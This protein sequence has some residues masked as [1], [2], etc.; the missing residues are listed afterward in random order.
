VSSF[1]RRPRCAVAVLVVALGVLVAGG[2]PA[3]AS[4]A[5]TG[6]TDEVSDNGQCSLREAITVLNEG[7]A[8]DCTNTAT[9][10]TTINVPAGDYK[11]TLR[12]SGDDA[13]ETGDL[14]LLGSMT[15]QGA[16]AGS[17]FIDGDTANAG[18]SPDRVL[19]IIQG[20]GGQMN[21]INGVTVENGQ[22]PPA[23][24][25]AANGGGILIR[26]G[27]VTVTLNDDVVTHNRRGRGRQGCPGEAAAESRAR[28][29]CWP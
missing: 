14:D 23:T 2:S 27:P 8:A 5:V 1:G 6:T 22:A 28:A 24:T 13:N 25:I 11:L 9:D 21:A 15:I 18:V 12:G 3:R 17:T 26:G 4:I 19:D 7:S 20:V 29:V 16:G 10:Q